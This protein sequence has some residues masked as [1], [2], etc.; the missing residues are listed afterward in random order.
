MS[1]LNLFV[2][3]RIEILAEKLADVLDRPLASPLTQEIIVV[4]SRGMER[5]ISMQ[6]ASFHGICA[7]VRFPFPRHS[8]SELFQAVLPEWQTKPFFDR[9]RLPGG[10]FICC[11]P[12]C[13][14]PDSSLWAPI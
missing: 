9:S 11:L 2:S 13:Y 7:N 14:F 4:Q 10:F 6:L 1:G 12:A 8:I 3:N 5:W